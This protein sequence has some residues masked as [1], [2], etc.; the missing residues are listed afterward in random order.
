MSHG[1]G[2]RTLFE[3]IH[4]RLAAGE[5]VALVAPNGA[6][7]STL[8]RIFVG[9]LAPDQGQVIRKNDARVGYFRQ[10][11]EFK[12]SGTV[13]EAF[14]AGFDDL[15]ALRKDL[16]AAMEDAACGSED[17]LNHLADLQ[18]R[19][20]HSRGDEL[21]SRVDAVAQKL[22]FSESDMARD[23]STLSGGERGRLSLGVIL[24]SAPDVLLLDE[25][26]NHLDLDTI[27]W[28]E[29]YL[30]AYR[31]AVL[32]V[33]HDRA[34]MDA[35][36]TETVELGRKGLRRYPASYTGYV[37]LRL[38]ELERER[39]GVDAQKDLVAKTEDFIRKNIAG[40]KTKQAQSRRRMLAK[41]DMLDAPEDVWAKAESVSF[42]FREVPRSG[43]IVLDAQNLG[44]VRGD[45]N[46]FS[47][48]DL[49]VRRGERIG[50]VGPNGA[51]KSTLMKMLAS[52]G[53]PGDTGTV[54]RGTNLAE[55]YYDQH[56]GDLNSSRTP[57]DEIRSVRGDLNDDGARDYLA[58]FRFSGDE[59]LRKVTGMSGGERSRLA[60]AKLLLEPR[61]LVFLDEPTNHLDIPAA[62]ILEEALSSFE[63]TVLLV[64]HDRRF[65][66]NIATRILHVR[67]GEVEAFV[68][69]YADFEES[70][71]RAARTVAPPSA[72]GAGAKNPAARLS[73]SPA[74]VAASASVAST[75]PKQVQT[76]SN[77]PP[78]VKG[79]TSYEELR[80]A[81]RDKERKKR[82]VAELETKIARHEQTLAKHAEK[83]GATP[84]EAWEEL[85]KLA[86]EEGKLRA[87]LDDDMAEWAAL[88][89][90]LG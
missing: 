79:P 5:R 61:N 82:R 54:K 53:M 7:K 25:P 12:A 80:A 75:A 56:L 19:Y 64:S 13:Q 76:A 3:G 87:D 46:L 55:G 22:G 17:K 8:M 37:D 27:G 30:S 4:F 63:G 73:A 36:T 89:E 45:K 21:E 67:G 41:M 39:A 83:Q 47:G 29:Q 6:G 57:V 65:L 68:G 66:E 1:Y 38:E 42:R 18:E 49:L 71:K 26:T 10:S 81:S 50:I 48:V 69:G 16:Q 51:G 52:Q 62:E 84:A 43:D 11:H 74:A 85:A 2:A 20:H 34:F 58:R 14:F 60:L 88:S 86:F 33:S 77:V 32:L 40:Q 70:R 59:A 72:K 23:V 44:A 31:G 15:L 9:E 28:L 35:V 24:A 78:P 90:D